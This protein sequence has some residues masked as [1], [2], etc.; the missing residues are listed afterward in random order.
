VCSLQSFP[1]FCSCFRCH[2]PTHSLHRRSPPRA[3]TNRRTHA[4]LNSPCALRFLPSPSRPAGPWAGHVAPEALRDAGPGAGTVQ[5]AAEPGGARPGGPGLRR[6]HLQ[7]PHSGVGAPAHG[8]AHTQS[9]T[10]PQLDTL[11]TPSRDPR[12]FAV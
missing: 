10:K 4:T 12:H 1:R 11:H 5:L 8:H 7:P 3:R 2:P 9:H 6:R